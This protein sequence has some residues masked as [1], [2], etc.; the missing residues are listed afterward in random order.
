MRHAK[1]LEQEARQAGTKQR[2]RKH[3]SRPLRLENVFLVETARLALNKRY[4][5]KNNGLN[6]P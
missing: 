3:K 2:R 4:L 1:P 5:N 6:Y